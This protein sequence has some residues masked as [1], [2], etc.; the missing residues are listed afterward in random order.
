MQSY[1]FDH[2]NRASVIMLI[3]M[4]V[5]GAVGASLFIWFS[6]V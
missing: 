4:C 1:S 3:V 6:C 5:M 2:M